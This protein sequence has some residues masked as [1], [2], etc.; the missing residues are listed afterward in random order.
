MTSVKY[1][2]VKKIKGGTS[3]PLSIWLHSSNQSHVSELSTKFLPSQGFFRLNWEKFELTVHVRNHLN[4]MKH[5]SPDH[6]LDFDIRHRP[7]TNM[8]LCKEGYLTYK[9]SLVYMPIFCSGRLSIQRCSSVH[10]LSSSTQAQGCLL[11]SFNHVHKV[12]GVSALPQELFSKCAF[13]N[14]PFRCDETG[15]RTS[16]EARHFSCSFR[17][18][19]NTAPH[20]LWL[21]GPHDCTRSRWKLRLRLTTRYLQRDLRQSGRVAAGTGYLWAESSRQSSFQFLARHWSNHNQLE[22]GMQEGLC[23]GADQGKSV[24]GG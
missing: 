10:V 6:S 12:T 13:G 11:L 1:R 18:K 15:F 17:R 21:T 2:V 4:R 14:L 19:A 16:E 7:Y 3:L 9:N 5:M 8:H 20:L 22:H 24:A 23:R